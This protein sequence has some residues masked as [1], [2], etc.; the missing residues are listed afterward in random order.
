M[1]KVKELSDV[2]NQVKPL[3]ELQKEKQDALL[4]S[5]IKKEKSEQTV[6]FDGRCYSV[7]Q[8]NYKPGLSKK[9]LVK[10]IEAYNKKHTEATVPDDLLEFIE[11]Q[12]ETLKKPPRFRLAIKVCE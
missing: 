1:Q 5:L 4:A 6:S 3:Q 10:M 8:N 2:L 9:V 7:K 11:K 12:Q